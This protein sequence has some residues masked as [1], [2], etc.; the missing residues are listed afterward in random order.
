M[1]VPSVGRNVSEVC[2]VL[3]AQ[4]K[5]EHESHQTVA[6]IEEIWFQEGLA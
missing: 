4:R 6:S 5:K 2:V 1:F 3:V